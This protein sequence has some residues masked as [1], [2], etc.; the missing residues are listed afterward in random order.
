MTWQL[1]QKLRLKLEAAVDVNHQS[2]QGVISVFPWEQLRR[3][4]AQQSA[5][6]LASELEMAVALSELTE[7]VCKAGL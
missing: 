5:E 6:L 7:V 1:A 4:V 3:L 2:V